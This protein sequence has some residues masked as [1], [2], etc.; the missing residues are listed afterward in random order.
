M[1]ARLQAIGTAMPDNMF[2]Q[3]EILEELFAH[4][5]GW[6]PAWAEVFTAS[7]V[8]RRA[9][10]IDPS[11]YGRPRSTADRMREFAPAARRLG[12]DAARRAL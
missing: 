5:P 2:K 8:E 9:S 3:A 1:I 7:G 4:Q 6:D 12:A 10:V 11:W